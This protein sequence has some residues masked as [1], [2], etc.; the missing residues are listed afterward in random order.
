MLKPLAGYVL[1]EPAPK[2]TKTASGIVLP[3]S[4]DEKPQEGKVLACGDD[5]VEEGKTIACPVKVNDKV[6]Y[7]KWGGNEIKVDGKELLL[8]K[9]EDLMAVVTK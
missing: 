5:L 2:E 1:I 8:T 7:K 9:F 4:A 3:D 6:V